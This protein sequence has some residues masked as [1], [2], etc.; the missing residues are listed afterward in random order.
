MHLVKRFVQSLSTRELD[1]DEMEL[2]NRLLS[3]SELRLWNAM[4]LPDRRHSLKVLDRFISFQPDATHGE[5]VGVA[6]H[7]VGKIESGLGTYG[8]VLATLFGP[9]TKRFAV[10]LDHEA[11]GAR[12]LRECGSDE[13]ALGILESSG[14]PAAI[15]AYRRADHY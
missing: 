11:I 7:D 10:Y 1:A 4:S 15:D 12:L 5:K 13:D 14:R 8:R 2:V 9:R 3:P 6:L